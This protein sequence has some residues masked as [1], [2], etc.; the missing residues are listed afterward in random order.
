[1]RTKV[2]RKCSIAALGLVLGQLPVTRPGLALAASE[3][4]SVPGSEELLGVWAGKRDFGPVVR[5]DLTIERL[6]SNWFAEIAGYRLKVEHVGGVFSFEIP[7]G[8]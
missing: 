7:G 1:M 8:L 4:I 6:G 2:L 5:G 3:E